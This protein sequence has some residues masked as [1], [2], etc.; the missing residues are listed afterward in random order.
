MVKLQIRVNDLGIVRRPSRSIR[1]H[2]RECKL[3]LVAAVQFASPKSHLRIQ[4][5]G[6]PL[7]VKRKIDRACRETRE[8]N[9]E[10][11]FLY[12][13]AKKLHPRLL[14]QGEQSLTV[15]AGDGSPQADWSGAQTRW[16]LSGR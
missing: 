4:N 2:G 1:S 5:V 14:T 6:D 9:I 16:V 10:S 11:T 12:V 13:I 8:V 7:P 15:T 3:H